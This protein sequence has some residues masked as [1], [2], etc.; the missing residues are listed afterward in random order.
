MHG[1]TSVQ[2][3]RQ[4]ARSISTSQRQSQLS[5]QQKW[6]TTHGYLAYLLVRTVLWQNPFTLPTVVRYNFSISRWS[7]PGISRTPARDLAGLSMFSKLQTPYNPN[8]PTRPYVLER[9]GVKTDRPL[10]LSE[11]STPSTSISSS[12]SSSSS[13]PRLEWHETPLPWSMLLL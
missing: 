6:D 8:W 7:S 13:L 1:S 10:N 4:Y 5:L 12:S 9:K 3:P 2:Q 11:S